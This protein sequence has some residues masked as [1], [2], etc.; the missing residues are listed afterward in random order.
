[1]LHGVERTRVWS[2]QEA[3]VADSLE[4]DGDTGPFSGPGDTSAIVFRVED[5]VAVGLLFGSSRADAKEGLVGEIVHQSGR[6]YAHELG[7]VLRVL[8]L[9]WL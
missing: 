3:E 2:T 7:A 5:F 8:Q 4:I 9:R 6:T 1:M